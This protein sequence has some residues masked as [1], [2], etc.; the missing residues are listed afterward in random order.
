MLYKCQHFEPNEAG[1][2]E[3]TADNQKAGFSYNNLDQKTE[4]RFRQEFSLAERSRF[5]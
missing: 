1:G 4:Q 2:V 3:S 5:S